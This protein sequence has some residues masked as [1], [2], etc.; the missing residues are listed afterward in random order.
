[1]ADPDSRG[2]IQGHG[3]PDILASNTIYTVKERELL[4]GRRRDGA[5]VCKPVLLPRPG[6][7]AI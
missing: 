3:E 1:V 7:R 2:E 5:Q 6:I 4:G